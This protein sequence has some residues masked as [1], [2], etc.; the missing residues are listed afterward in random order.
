MLYLSRLP[1]IN[2]IDPEKIADLNYYLINQCLGP[3]EVVY[4]MGSEPDKVYLLKSGV[5]AMYSIIELEETNKFP[6]GHNAWEKITTHR[7]YS[8]KLRH[9]N[10]D[11]FFGHQELI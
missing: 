8:Y 3:G 4:E 5:V 9:L 7:T 11:E 2:R 10:Q 6:T 1:F